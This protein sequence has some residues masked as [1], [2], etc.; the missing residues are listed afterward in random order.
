VTTQLLRFYSRQVS[1]RWG[2]V[3]LRRS[4]DENGSGHSTVA[5]L[6]LSAVGLAFQV[7]YFNNSVGVRWEMEGRK[8]GVPIPVLDDKSV[9]DVTA[10][11]LS[12]A[13]AAVATSSYVPRHD[14]MLFISTSAILRRHFAC[15]S[16]L[17]SSDSSAY[18]AVYWRKA[19]RNSDIVDVVPFSSVQWFWGE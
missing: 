19:P 1:I 11:S 2:S 18:C 14:C 16:M 6:G 9:V 17:V 13:A 8:R 12:L 4:R 3:R 5:V 10:T 7:E 15:V